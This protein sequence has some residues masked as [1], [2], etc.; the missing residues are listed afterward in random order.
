MNY[1]FLLKAKYTYGRPQQG[2]VLHSTGTLILALSS[3][4]FTLMV[5]IPSLN[6]AVTLL[7]STGRGNQT[8]RVKAAAPPNERSVES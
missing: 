7:P 8:V 2:F 4:L 1:I 6:F 3:A 5:S